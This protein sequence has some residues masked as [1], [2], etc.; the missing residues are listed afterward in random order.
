VALWEL[1]IAAP[2]RRLGEEGTQLSL[3]LE[4]PE[5]PALK[6]LR[7]WEAM[8]ADY[9]TTGLTAA[10]HPLALLRPD[11]EGMASSADLERVAHDS[12][13]RVAGLVVARQRPG[14]ANGVTFLLLEDELGTINLIVPQAVYERDRLAVRTEPLVVAEG[15]L[16]R[17]ASGGGAINVL[18]RSLVA[19][20]APAA[21]RDRPPAPVA[22][23]SPLDAREL[24][25]ARDARAAAAGSGSDAG[26]RAVA[27]AVMSFA[28]GRRR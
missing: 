10:Q 23:F 11:L 13:V 26:F 25:R 20:E 3:P 28:S 24:E 19:L 12:F 14:T 16:E 2:G 5:A 8:I 21:E 1:G 7:P 6:A 9:A 18:V 15:K 22:D 4:L 27:P 17:F